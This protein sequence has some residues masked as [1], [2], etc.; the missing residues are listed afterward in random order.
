[1]RLNRDDPGGSR[2][3]PL[4]LAMVVGVA[5]TV[6]A[7][8]GMTT[9]D[10]AMFCGSCHSMDEAE[11]THRQSVHAALACNECHAPHDLLA[12]IPFKAK[13]GARDILATLTGSI[14]DLIHP[15]EETMHVVQA[16][17]QRCHSATTASVAMQAK[18]YCTDCHRHVPHTPKLPIA[19][20]SAA[21]A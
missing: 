11:L 16:N 5:L 12:K 10:Q 7:A 21:D 15:G 2:W 4:I 14:P 9:T 1:M 19:K 20:R 8:V 13:E 3:R 18:Q 6:G 17:C